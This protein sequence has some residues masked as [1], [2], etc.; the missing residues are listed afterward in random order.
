MAY[1]RLASEVEDLSTATS[2]GSVIMALACS[3]WRSAAERTTATK[4]ADCGRTAAAAAAQL[5]ARQLPAPVTAVRCQCQ[6]GDCLH[7]SC[8]CSSSSL[9][10]GMTA[11]QK[12]AAKI[13][14]CHSHRLSSRTTIT[15]AAAAAY[16]ELC[17]LL[18]AIV[19][20]VLSRQ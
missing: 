6:P 3:S 8:S 19:Q 14:Q 20:L 4:A 2:R 17:W 11:L 5:R 10:Q 16:G 15:T 12:A 7:H 1:S 9:Q 18:C 13:D